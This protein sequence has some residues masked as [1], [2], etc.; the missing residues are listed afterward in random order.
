MDVL[1]RL[2][3]KAADKLYSTPPARHKDGST[4]IKAELEYN[5]K[6]MHLY[7]HIDKRCTLKFKDLTEQNYQYFVDFKY[8]KTNWRNYKQVAELCVW[9][10]TRGCDGLIRKFKGS[11]YE[12]K[13]SDKYYDDLLNAILDEMVLQD[14][15]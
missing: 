9:F 6:E 13:I 7:I 14:I 4:I 11:W 8:N 5:S 15:A 12:N 2:W 1:R 3:I 10:K